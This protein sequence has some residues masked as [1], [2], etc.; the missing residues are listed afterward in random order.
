MQ[1]MILCKRCLSD[2]FSTFRQLHLD[3]LVWP[4]P[5]SGQVDGLDS[6]LWMSAFQKP[7]PEIWLAVAEFCF[8]LYFLLWMHCLPTVL[9][10]AENAATPQS[11]LPRY[12]LWVRPLVYPHS[13]HP[14]KGIEVR[15][16]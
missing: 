8:V 3:R 12:R 6:E 14:E 5:V 2:L 4:V 15:S 11:T 13:S 1:G 16:W 10:T 9:L 7:G